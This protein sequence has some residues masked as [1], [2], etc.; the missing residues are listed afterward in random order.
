M[1]SAGRKVHP[2]CCAIIARTCADHLETVLDIATMPGGN[3]FHFTAEEVEQ[4]RES[5]SV[6][7]DKG[8]CS[9]SPQLLLALGYKED[10]FIVKCR[11]RDDKQTRP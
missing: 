9:L 8:T 6:A 5:I 11:Q 4:L 2:N 1:A 3:V 7:F 10:D